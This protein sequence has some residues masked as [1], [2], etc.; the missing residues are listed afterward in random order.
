MGEGQVCPLVGKPRVGPAR[1]AAAKRSNRKKTQA[2]VLVAVEELVSHKGAGG[3]WGM[4]AV[5]RQAGVNKVLLYRYYGNFQGLVQC[6]EHQVL[7]AHLKKLDRGKKGRGIPALKRFL[8]AVH[9]G[10]QTSPGLRW[11]L[12]RELLVGKSTLQQE[13]EERIARML[14]GQDEHTKA[15]CALVLSGIYMSAALGQSA[16]LSAERI[17]ALVDKLTTSR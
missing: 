9:T 6:Y 7:T 17:E 8:L 13:H 12:A 16:G 10:L 1:V 14:A 4:S 15:L 2:K 11:L 5:A 3:S